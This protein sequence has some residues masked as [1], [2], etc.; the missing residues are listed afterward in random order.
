MLLRL[1]LRWHNGGSRRI[2][3]AMAPGTVDAK[4]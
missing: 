2:W 1:L 3:E 4:M